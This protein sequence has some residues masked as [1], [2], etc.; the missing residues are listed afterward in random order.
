MSGNPLDF[1]DDPETYRSGK[2]VVPPANRAEAKPVRRLAQAELPGLSARHKACP[3]C[4]E[5]ILAIA[6]KCKHCQS[7]LDAAGPW[8]PS[9]ITVPLILCA[10][11]YG[12]SLLL[13]WIEFKPVFA[14]LSFA[15]PLGRLGICIMVAVMALLALGGFESVRIATNAVRMKPDQLRTRVKRLLLLAFTAGLL[16]ILVPFFAAFMAMNLWHCD[17]NLDEQ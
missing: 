1:L 14:E 5:Q 7:L 11:S 17:G 3:M 16:T 6:K 12:F 9:Q 4:G 13:A 2:R 15:D 8:P 10:G